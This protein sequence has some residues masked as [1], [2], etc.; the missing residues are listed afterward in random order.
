[1]EK[2]DGIFSKVKIIKF[3]SQI[4][5]MYMMGSTRQDTGEEGTPQWASLLSGSVPHLLLTHIPHRPL[6]LVI[7]HVVQKRHMCGPQTTDAGGDS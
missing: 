7:V 2:L 6:T 5:C 4:S 1:M 3:L